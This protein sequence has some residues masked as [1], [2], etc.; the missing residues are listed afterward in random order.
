MRIV[1]S[2]LFKH[3]KTGIYHS[4]KA[5]PEKLRAAAG[6]REWKV[7]LGSGELPSATDAMPDVS[8]YTLCRSSAIT[9]GSFIDVSKGPS[10]SPRSAQ[11][12]KPLQ[13]R[14]ADSG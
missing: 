14:V 10:H 5:I 6:K 1:V 12:K 13:P 11:F 2:G 9:A 7:S 8:A 3:P 4:R